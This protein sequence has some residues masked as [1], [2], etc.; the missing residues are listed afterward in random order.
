MAVFHPVT[1]LPFE[2]RARIWEL[3]VESRIVDIS[4][5]KGRFGLEMRYCTWFRQRRSLQYCSLAARHA[6][7]AYTSKPSRKESCRAMFGSTSMLISFPLAIPTSTTSNPN[8]CSYDGSNLKERT[9]RR[10][11][12]SRARD[13]E[14]FNN[15]GGIHVVC[16]DGL[17]MWQEAWE[18]VHWPCPED[19]VRFIDKESGQQVNG[20]EIDKMWE[21]IVGPPPEDSGSERS[22]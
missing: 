8:A 18:T 17:L 4:Y 11:Y 15:L 1:R 20:W 6:I 21:D 13:L 7:R 12:I 9:P 16:E 3:A 10:S 5:L 14:K 19:M 22:Q 2:L